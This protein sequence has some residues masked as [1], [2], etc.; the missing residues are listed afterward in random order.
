MKEFNWTS[1][2]QLELNNADSLS[3]SPSTDTVDGQQH[4]YAKRQM[5]KPQKPFWNNILY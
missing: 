5:E 2:V 4:V 3:Q 1:S